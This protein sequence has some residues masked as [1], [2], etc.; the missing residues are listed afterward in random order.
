M[1]T[2]GHAA[3]VPATQSDFTH[4]LLGLGESSSPEIRSTENAEANITTEI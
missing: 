3:G 1:S 4:V 2:Q